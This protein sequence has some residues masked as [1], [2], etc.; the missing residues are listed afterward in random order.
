M[1]KII[2]MQHAEDISFKVES[3]L[4]FL[5]P[6]ISRWFN[7]RYSSL[8]EPQAKAIPLIHGKKNVLVS[9]PTGTGK[10]MTGFLSI[11]NELFIMSREERLEDKIYCVYISPLKAL[12]NDIDKNLRQPL[13]QINELVDELGEKYPGIRVAV[14]SGDTPQSERQKM[15]RKPPHILITTPE[16]FSLALSAPKFREK[17]D[18]VRWVILDEIHE[19]SATK[20]G[21]LLSV[22][23][24]RLGSI[25]KPFVRIGLSATQAPLELI[26]SYLTGYD[27]DNPRGCEIVS[28]DTKKFLDLKTITPVQDLTKTQVEVASDKMYDMLAAMIQ[29]HSTTLVF[30]N[31]RSGAEHVAMRLKARGIESIEAHHS[32][33]GRD[34][35][36]EVEN[37]LKAGELKCVITS[38]S[39]ELGIDIGYIDLVVQINSPKSVSKGLQRIG[40]SGHGLNE[41]SKGRFLVFNI[42]DL[43]ECAVLTKAAYDQNIDKVVVPTNSLDVLSQV[44]VGMSLEKVWGIDEAYAVVR[45]SYSFHTLDYDDYIATLNYLGGRIEDSTIYSKIWL[46]EEERTFGKKRSTRMIYFMNIGTI[47]EEADYQVINEKGR[48]LGQLSDKFVERLKAGDIFVLGAK[49]YMFLKVNKNRV[50]V[51]D[52]TGMRPTV[53]SWT[54]EMLPRSYDLGVL[55]G[56]FRRTAVEKMHKG[57]DVKKWLM[58]E[59]RLDEYGANSMISYIGTQETFGIPT[60]RELLI[61]GYIDKDNFYNLIYHIPL[62]RRVN[63]ALSRAYAHVISNK[64]EV[65]TRVT[66]TDD[67]FMLTSPTKIP[68]DEQVSLLKSSE[69][70]DIVRR[71][72]SNT[73]VFKQRFRHCAARALMVLRKYK[74]YDISVVR[75]QLRSDRVLGILDKMKNF[76]VI[77]ETY[78]EITTDM[79]DVPRAKKYVKEVVEQKHYSIRNYSKE[80]SPFSFGII[81]AGVS[82]LVLMEDR[83]KI[84]KELQSKILDRIYGS[85]KVRFMFSDPKV[86][87]SFFSQKVPEIK[88]IDTYEDFLRHFAYVDPFK[89]K[90]NSPFPYASVGTMD[91][92]H[93]MISGNRMVSIYMRGTQWTHISYYNDYLT[94]FKREI[95]PDEK[96]DR[97]IEA[98]TGKSFGEIRDHLGLGENELKDRLINLEAAYLIRKR[99]RGD[100]TTYISNDIPHIPV[101]ETEAAKRILAMII[102]SFGP[103]TLDELL[104]KLPVSQELMEKALGELTSQ[105]EIVYDYITPVFVKQYMNSRDLQ[106]LI[107]GSQTDLARERIM[108][109]STVVSDVGQYFE[110]YGFAIDPWDIRVRVESYSD[111]QFSDL[112]EQGKVVYGRIIKH[113]LSYCS[114]ELAESLYCLRWDKP[115]EETESIMH[116]ISEGFRNEKVLTERSGQPQKVVRQLLKDLEYRLA[117]SRD[118]E[119]QFN[120][121]FGLEEPERKEDA[122]KYLVDIYGPVT[123]EELSRTFWIYA[124][125]TL[126]K[127]GIKPTYF[128]N[129]LYYGSI[130]KQKGGNSI[131]IRLQDPLSIYLGRVYEREVD[132]NARLIAHGNDDATF[133]MQQ[134]DSILWIENIVL[135]EDGS[136]RDLLKAVRDIKDRMKLTSVVLLPPSD[137]FITDAI[138]MGFKQS[139]GYLSIGDAEITD[140]SEEDLFHHACRKSYR[141]KREGETIYNMLRDDPLGVRTEIEANYLGIRNVQLNNYFQSRLIFTFNGPFGAQ[142]YAPLEVISIYR[143]IKNLDLST[144]DQRVLR[145]VIEDGGATESEVLSRLKKSIFGTKEVLKKLYSYNLVA[146]DFGRK[147]V[148]VPEKYS[149]GEAISIILKSLVDTFGFFD[150]DR[151]AKISGVDI[152]DDY[153][154]ARDQLLHAGLI[155]EIISAERKTVYVET[156]FEKPVKKVTSSSVASPKD[157]QTLYFQDYIKSRFG[158]TNMYF[159]IKNG[160]I[161]TALQTRKNQYTLRVTRIF[162]EKKYRESAKKEL[163]E[164]GYAVIFP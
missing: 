155:K 28:I 73:E 74:G 8:T 128:K 39:L 3:E 158:T 82:D 113:K 65:N 134:K 160:E 9:S 112:L 87:E 32:S 94:L 123:A 78:H 124:R 60:N 150:E 42:D 80:T 46:D 109:L 70:E 135:Y 100:V 163:N 142:T 153:R 99:F 62:G 88:D 22:N 81:F 126:E 58:D 48:H 130:G 10:T 55:V 146:K 140:V 52:A 38:T 114:I 25:A 136:G 6:V 33:L 115:S 67:G 63:D 105:G 144:E 75:Q 68:L 106:Q 56:E 16:S 127:T 72:L 23:L 27:G 104:I 118:V 20:R 61:E 24:E 84:L 13:D 156:A 35:R 110:K 50:S 139:A 12:A 143:A 101:D 43:M 108:G 34:T 98:C 117:I 5:D 41:L 29:E 85:E 83:S 97:I 148:F 15:L 161:I 18:M 121:L 141:R 49:T 36:F 102:S 107:G 64:Y 53:P 59:Y 122:M 86:I 21:S 69:F 95:S 79:M 137:E 44:L 116:L 157:L 96:N 129:N 125:E 120:P 138:S 152:D 66:V 30:T 37:K 132:F 133:S 91:L 4:P 90:F 19:I 2:H 164:F 45:N 77:K 31:T 51:K 147:L 89:N 54:G 14:R 119:G 93:E 17:F 26:A 111:S 151:Y 57:E 131:V 7:S 149:R 1:L 40:R 92:S 11:I 47:P 103:L 145:T 162:G 76:P 71:S 154:Q 159:Y